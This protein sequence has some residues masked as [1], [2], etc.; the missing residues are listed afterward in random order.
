[1]H[2]FSNKYFWLSWVRLP[3]HT[4]P[5]LL[6]IHSPLIIYQGG[7]KCD[8]LFV[9]AGCLRFSC[10]SSGR[11]DATAA[12]EGGGGEKGREEGT[13]G[14]GT[15]QLPNGVWPR[16]SPLRER[17]REKKNFGRRRKKK[18]EKKIKEKKKIRRKKIQRRLEPQLAVELLLSREFSFDRSAGC[19]TNAC[20]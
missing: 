13:R 11:S 8:S 12:S 18:K 15:K 20:V 17:E 19:V 3:G 10:V 1:M 7:G 4:T 14:R 5:V 6:C 9:C 16:K 2:F